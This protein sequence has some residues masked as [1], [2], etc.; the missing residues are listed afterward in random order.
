M[1][2]ND[3]KRLRDQLGITQAELATR[4]NQIDPQLR[5]HPATVSR[6]EAGRHAPSPH[7]AAAMGILARRHQTGDASAG[8]RASEHLDLAAAAL[9]ADGSARL[10]AILR[11]LADGQRA[12]GHDPLQ[13]TADGQRLQ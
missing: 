1:T 13:I 10:A 5:V 4:I 11:R 3:V 9:E 6:W 12:S 7:A 8:L 2:G